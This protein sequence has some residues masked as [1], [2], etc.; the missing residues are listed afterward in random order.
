MPAVIRRAILLFGSYA[1]LLL[2]V[3]VAGFLA[4][5]VGIWAAIIWGVAIVVG[6]ALFRRQRL[7][8]LGRG[9]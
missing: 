5:A 4:S 9:E 6:L 2:V 7:N 1:S 3:M 8:R